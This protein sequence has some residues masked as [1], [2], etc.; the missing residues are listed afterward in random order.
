MEQFLKTP[1][2]II[3]NK[4]YS[5]WSGTSEF[6]I[7]Q[8]LTSYIIRKPNGNGLSKL[9]YKKYHT[10]GVL[11][12]RWDQKDIAVNVGLRSPGHISDLLSSMDRK[13]IIIKHYEPW[14]RK[15]LCVYE[16][17][18]YNRNTNKENYYAFDY[19]RKKKAETTLKELN[20]VSEYT[21]SV[22]ANL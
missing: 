9:L 13:G 6:K 5:K 2:S 21:N 18:R 8:Y 11:V 1:Y 3:R 15:L 20:V 10:N 16:F 22:Q 14:N 7:W 4:E 12:A 19:F 17:G